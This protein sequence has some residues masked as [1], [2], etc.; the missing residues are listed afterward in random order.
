MGRLARQSNPTETTAAGAWPAAGDDT[1]PAGNGWLYSQQ[2]YDWNGRPLVTTNTDGT[3]K[4]ASYAGCGCAGGAVVTLTDEGTID[5]GVAKRRQQKIYSDVLGRTTKNEVFNWQGGTVYS[6]TVN[7]YNA[8][9]QVTLTRQFQG[10]APG[11]LSC[12]S[13][14]CQQ[15]TMTYDGHG[16]LITRHVPEQNAGTNTVWNYN[17]DDTV[18]KVTDARGASQTFTHNSRH[19]VTGITYAAPVGITIPTAPSFGYDGAGNRISMTDGTGNVSYHYDQLSRMDWEDRTFA[20]LSGSTYRLSYGYNLVGALTSITDPFNAQ[21]GY[22]Y[23]TA[24]RIATVS[25]SGFANV[26]TYASNIQYRA[27][28]ALKHLA[29]GNTLAVDMNYN[30]RL[31]STDFD[32]H[33]A[34]ASLLKSTYQ[35]NADGRIRTIDD[36]VDNLWDRSYSFDFRGLLT[37]A[38]AGSAAGLQGTTAAP[39]SETFGH[40]AWGNLTSRN[41]TLWSGDGDGFIAS[42]ADNR[43]QSDAG[44]TWQHDAAGNVLNITH[45]G[46]P[47]FQQY[48]IDAAGQTAQNTEHSRHSFGPQTSVITR[49]ITIDQSYDGDVQRV[50]RVESKTTQLNNN[51][52]TTSQQTSYD[53]RSSALGGSV[54]T[55]LNGQGQKQKGYV[56]AGGELLA[57]QQKDHLGNDQVLWSH[58]DSV[59]NTALESNASGQINSA[60]ESQRLDLDPMGG[61][62]PPTDPALD[63]SS[64]I[65]GAMGSGWYKTA[66]DPNNPESGCAWNGLSTPCSRLGTILRYFQL[67]YIVIGRDVGISIGGTVTRNRGK[68]KDKQNPNRTNPK[69]GALVTDSMGPRDVVTITDVTIVG[70]G[71]EYAQPQNSG[72]ISDPTSRIR[73]I[74]TGGSTALER[75]RLRV[76]R[77]IEFMVNSGSCNAA[78]KRYG[79]ATPFDLV[80]SGKITLSSPAALTNSS[81][82]RVLGQAL[83]ARSGSLP[84]ATRIDTLGESHAPAV[85]LRNDRTGNAI[86]FFGPDAFDPAYLDEAVPHEFIHAG[87]QGQKY[88]LPGWFFGHDLSGYNEEA[89]AYIMAN[90]KDH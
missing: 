20:G 84:N 28:G 27:W 39:Y 79:L 48:A 18:L 89:Y 8:R 26:S 85:T 82:N 88:S 76:L 1:P 42:Y 6:T 52:P 9:D 44:G 75:N 83:G 3:T 59:S 10:S 54:T 70:L 46:S 72:D 55:E 71:G 60:V 16:R 47:D 56:F 35:Y 15:T 67:D 80:N 78:F 19:M 74:D 69:T 31:Q 21:I 66:A 22:G 62:I 86:I 33:S 5:G 43:R 51:P 14:T 30:G 13:G 7:T 63:E 61:A 24:G 77:K 68:W 34:S 38:G 29:Y 45:S 64:S 17:S 11:D 57:V 49:D 2:T 36:Q 50:K 58:T 65:D 90:C 73:I 23:D 87:G 41:T 40:D 81:Y 4:T 37:D 25:G 12:P 53:L 32:V